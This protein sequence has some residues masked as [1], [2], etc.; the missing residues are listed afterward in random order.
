MPHVDADLLS[1]CEDAIGHTFRDRGLLV[2]ALTHGSAKADDAPSNETYEF[3]GDAILGMIV[4]TLIF[5]DH[6]DADEGRLTKIKAQAVSK[7]SLHLV[8]ERLGLVD[9][10]IVGNMFADRRSITD[11]IVADCVEALIAAIYLDAGFDAAIDFVVGNFRESIH[12]AA[13]EPGSAD[14]KSRLGQWV[15]KTRRANPAYDVTD[16]TGPDHARTFTIVVRIDGRE[17]ATATGPSK[18]AAE[19][20][21]ARLALEIIEKPA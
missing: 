1:R 19:Q 17:I 15:Q 12:L 3:L 11:S 21:A 9:F 5:A 4:S 8:A 7:K 13:D 2:Q 18:K 10:V 14:Y 20:E 6:P 16:V